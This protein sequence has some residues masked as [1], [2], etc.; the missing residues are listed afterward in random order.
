MLPGAAGVGG[1]V[2]A[3][4]DGEIGAAQAFSAADIDGVGIRWGYG[5]RSNRARGLV[6]EDGIPGAA[7]VGGLPDSAIVRGHVEDILM[8]GNAGDGH[9][10]STAKG[11][12]RAPVKVL[13]QGRV[14]LLCTERRRE[15][16]N[17]KTG[18][19]HPQ[20]SSIHSLSSTRRLRI[21]QRN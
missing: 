13:V 9:G 15:K 16:R 3:I 2:H 21:N 5:E 12:D 19:Q 11:A 18:E 8:A 1:L 14:I 6:I 10:A 20:I 17:S 4:A 7:E